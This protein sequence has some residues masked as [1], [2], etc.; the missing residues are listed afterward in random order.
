MDVVMCQGKAGSRVYT[1][2]CSVLS[3]TVVLIGWYTGHVA[4]R[5][6]N[7]YGTA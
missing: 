6:T 1:N 7:D 2:K 4:E 5:C 3:A